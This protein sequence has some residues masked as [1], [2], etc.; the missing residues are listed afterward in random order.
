MTWFGGILFIAWCIWWVRGSIWPALMV[1]LFA[2]AVEGLSH[3]DQGHF[4]PASTII[5]MAVLSISAFIPH[6][7]ARRRAR[8]IERTLHGVSF[9]SVRD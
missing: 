5:A 6:L 9:L 3:A 1:P 4:D 2:I 7:V 8:Q